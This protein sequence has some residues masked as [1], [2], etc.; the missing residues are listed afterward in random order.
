MGW[1]D[2]GNWDSGGGTERTVQYVKTILPSLMLAL[3]ERREAVG[4]DPV[5]FY[6]AGDTARTPTTAYPAEADLVGMPFFGGP[7]GSVGNNVHKLINQIR[8]LLAGFELTT[9]AWDSSIDYDSP[10]ECPAGHVAGWC[11]SSSDATLWTEATLTTAVAKGSLEP[12]RV[13]AKNQ[14]YVLKGFLDRMLYPRVDLHISGSPIG[15]TY[16]NGSGGT[17]SVVASFSRDRHAAYYEEATAQDAWDAAV[18]AALSADGSPLS[19]IQCEASPAGGGLWKGRIADNLQITWTTS[20]LSGA[21]L[22]TTA[23]GFTMYGEYVHDALSDLAFLVGATSYSIKDAVGCY[24][25][26]EPGPDYMYGGHTF[27]SAPAWI[28]VGSDSVIDIAWDGYAATVPCSN[29]I[30]CPMPPKG[31]G[32]EPYQTIKPIQLALDITAE[33][34][35]QA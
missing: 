18:A 9:G 6:K 4:L 27:A 12:T 5:L 34:T 30:V 35:D 1:P 33:L 16:L 32:D 10:I 17:P 8:A 24:W 25:F 29:L 7:T 11:V 14:W 26:Q 13:Q 21:L 22:A 28:T 19:N 31:T 2:S 20:C 15:G 23:H 3:N